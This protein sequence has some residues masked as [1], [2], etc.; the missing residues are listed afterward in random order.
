M[1]MPPRLAAVIA[2]NVVFV[3]VNASSPS[4]GVTAETFGFAFRP[5]AP[6]ALYPSVLI[7]DLRS[8]VRY[9]RQLLLRT[10]AWCKFDNSTPAGRRVVRWLHSVPW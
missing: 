5:Y 4:P 3:T 6:I 10:G 2:P 8:F 9:D 7:I 1:S